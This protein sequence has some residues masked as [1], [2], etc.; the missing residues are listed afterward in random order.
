MNWFSYLIGSLLHQDHRNP[1]TELTR[2][3]YNGDSRGDLT[4]VGAVNRTEKLPQLSILSDCRPGS[5]NE[6]ASQPF[7]SGAGDRSPI[8]SLSG[9]ML[10]GHQAQK[11]SQLTDAFKFSPIADAGQELAGGNPADAWNRLQILD[12]LRELGIVAAKTSDLGNRLKNLLLMKLNAGKQSIEFKAHWP[13][14]GKLSQLILH[15][16]RPL[17]AG[18]SRGKLDSFEEQQRFN[19]LLHSRQLA[20]QHIAQLGKMAKV[21]VGGRGTV[22]ALELSCTQML[23]QGFTI[24][25]IGLQPLTWRSGNHRRRGNQT[26]I[27]LGRQPI[28]QPIPGRSSLIDKGNLLIREM[29]ADIMQQRLRLMRHVQRSD[30]SLMIRKRHRHT[31]FAHVQS[32]KDIIVPGY[33]RTSHCARLLCP[34]FFQ[35]NHLS[36]EA[37]CE[38]RHPSYKSQMDVLTFNLEAA[39]N[40]LASIIPTLKEAHDSAS[41]AE[42]YFQQAKS[43][44]FRSL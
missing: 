37:R 39:E 25:P 16:K 23:R 28:I 10:A 33:K 38:A 36:Q 17:T 21:A 34:W 24:E 4:R 8:H 12:A 1:H 26:G 5:L 13:R 42:A 6:F 29:L 14:A 44:Q 3:R 9:G 32:G 19:P 35:T 30:Q 15:Q 7:I 2:H 40:T 41:V 18:G 11:P 20:Y 27:S 43:R 22:D 31:L